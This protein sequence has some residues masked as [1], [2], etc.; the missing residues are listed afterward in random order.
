MERPR[1]R[2]QIDGM[3]RSSIAA[4]RWNWP[5]LPRGVRFDPSDEELMWHLLAETGE[6]EAEPHPFIG[7]FIISLNEDNQTFYSSPH[8]LPGIKKDGSLSYFFHKS[9]KAHENKRQMPRKILNGDL[10]NVCWHKIGKTKPVCID[11]VQKGLKTIMVLYMS[12]SDSDKPKKTN[13]M[14]HQYHVGGEEH[15]EGDLVISKIFYQVKFRQDDKIAHDL[16]LNNTA[17]T[18]EKVA[19]APRLCGIRGHAQNSN[20]ISMEVPCQAEEKRTYAGLRN[21]DYNNGFSK[22]ASNINISLSQFLSD[23]Q[24][25][26]NDN[27][28]C[29]G[30]AQHQSHC[31]LEVERSKS[32]ISDKAEISHHG[33]EEVLDVVMDNYD[34]KESSYSGKMYFNTAQEGKSSW[35]ML[36]SSQSALDGQ[37]HTRSSFLTPAPEVK[38]ETS[39]Q[40]GFD[41]HD[42][43]MDDHSVLSG[44]STQVK[45]EPFYHM[46]QI[47]CNEVSDSIS[48]AAVGMSELL[49]E[50]GRNDEIDHVTL[51]ERYKLML[52]S[53]NRAL[54]GQ[55]N[56]EFS[57]NIEKC[58]TVFASHNRIQGK[59]SEI[60]PR[61]ERREAPLVHLESSD[62]V[63]APEDSS[64]RLNTNNMKNC[65]GGNIKDGIQPN[66]A[67]FLHEECHHHSTQYDYAR[68]N[69]VTDSPGVVLSDGHL[70]VG[71]SFPSLMLEAD[72]SDENGASGNLLAC[73]ASSPEV[74]LPVNTREP[75]H[76]HDMDATMHSS[77]TA[78][79]LCEVTSPDD[80]SPGR[81]K[82]QQHQEHSC[83]CSD[84]T[85]ILGAEL[86]DSVERIL[87]H[88]DC[89]HP[90]K[91]T[92]FVFPIEV[93]AEPSEEITKCIPE[94]NAKELSSSFSERFS[95]S[96]KNLLA[97]VLSSCSVS[98]R[99]EDHPSILP[100]I[101]IVKKENI[102]GPATDFIDHIPLM[103][104]MQM[105]SSTSVANLSHDKSVDNALQALPSPECGSSNV[106]PEKKRFSLRR[107]RK[108]TATDSV[109][110]ALEEDAPGL[111]QVLLDKGITVEEIKLYGIVDNNADLPICSS[112]DSFEELETVIA[113]LFSEGPSVFKFPHVRQIKGFKAVY[114]LACLIS[115][116]EQARYLRFHRSPV[117]WGWC[118]DLQSFIFVFERHN[119]IVLERPEYGYATYF[120]ELV[121]SLPID[122]QIRRL[123][124]AMKLPCCSRTILLENKPLVVGED[125]T[126][127]EALVMEGYGW[128]RNT[129]LGTLLNYC[130]RVV[131][132]K[133]MERYNSEWRNKIGKLL[134]K[135]HDGG[136]T[137][138]SNL[139]KKVARYME[140]RNP[141]VKQDAPV[142]SN[143]P[144]KVAQYIE[145]QHP[146]VKLELEV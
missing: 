143:L 108:K 60:L 43:N 134:M 69:P 102:D 76:L 30:H 94:K 10:G 27:L 88:N 59:D 127:G 115:L 53:R 28:A 54:D 63:C 146:E 9:L 20:S 50:S 6:G 78:P 125:L 92:K 37:G 87:H 80:S 113:K 55:S 71:Q 42:S 89:N 61:E 95:S 40:A 116:I 56:L 109:E 39:G 34:P 118:R 122:W 13:W 51:Q 62:N 112:E 93:K 133:K 72:R 128:I 117:E 126:E 84:G 96:N 142:P 85:G 101:Y 29:P 22:E 140:Y 4:C 58:A 3:R 141:E 129:G 131:H 7:E 83:R 23:P 114:C 14:M 91:T 139:P 119:R 32:C 8:K 46:Q 74:R 121:G 52:S 17:G 144:K 66:N 120:F 98:G 136:R 70:A 138:L 73:E 11:G 111:L 2:R 107:K 18:E 65:F 45:V 97:S 137:I 123:V 12:M 48:P 77:M 57:G 130:D 75:G 21:F 38:F 106:N 86:L 19:V 25:Q 100:E 49:C 90:S 5:G 82:S 1:A 26:E 64:F 36:T 33:R 135:G 105:L 132:D 35:N 67:Q 31:G 99:H 68:S 124:T 15:V 47:S 79:C 81:C 16:G 103:E 41:L 44:H 145:Y 110:A 104:R 24:Q